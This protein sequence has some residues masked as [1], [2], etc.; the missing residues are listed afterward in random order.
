MWNRYLPPFLFLFLLL[1]TACSKESSNQTA[2]AFQFELVQASEVVAVES[3]EGESEEEID[4]PIVREIYVYDPGDRRDPF[5]PL[6]VPDGEET[7]DGE[8]KISVENLTLVGVI[9]GDGGR[10]AVLSDQAGYGYV[11][12]EGDSLPR[13]RVVS[14]SENSVVFELSQFGIV[15]KYEIVMQE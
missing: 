14:I 5:L 9:W 4:F 15:T 12:K 11:F 7:A 8:R 2:A 3:G 1:L 6:L 10:V 13:G